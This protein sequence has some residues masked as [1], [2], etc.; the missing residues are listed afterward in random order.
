MEDAMTAETFQVALP[1]L[2][3]HEGGYADHP[4]DPGGATKYGITRATLS[5]WRGR[6]V[7]RTDVRRLTREEAGAI[8]KAR[9]W[10]GVRADHLPAGVDYCVFDAAVNSGPGRAAKWLQAATRVAQ[11]GAVGPVT[12][13]AAGRRDPKELIDDI[14]DVRLAFLRGLSTWS[15]FGRGWERR[16]G[17]VRRVARA[18]AGEGHGQERALSDPNPPPTLPPLPS[19]PPAGSFWAAL[20]TF[21]RAVLTGGRR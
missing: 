1:H 5:S 13:A 16:V 3:G 21:M 11:D 9:Y 7:T 6:S 15:V 17:D 4:S 12:L 14:C 8:Y 19:R 18:M 2:F 20:A 10:D